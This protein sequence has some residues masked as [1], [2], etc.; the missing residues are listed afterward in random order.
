ME[1]SKAVRAELA[2]AMPKRRC[3]QQAELVA[4]VRFLG[5]RE[6]DVVDVATSHPAVARKVFLLGKGVPGVHVEGAEPTGA[7][8]QRYNVRLRLEEAAVDAVPRRDCCARAYLR[9]AWLSRGSV[10]DP[11]AGYHL[12]IVLPS[13]AEAA[14]VQG[15]LQRY[16]IG[17]G[18]SLRKG[19]HVVYVKDADG[20]AEFLRLTGAHGALLT[21]ED[22]RV[23]KHMRNRVNRLVNA[24]TANMEKVVG[25][26]LRQA[27]DIRLIE[28]LQGLEK[29]PS[30][31]KEVARLRLAHPDLS[32]AE[33]GRRLTPPLSK[34]AVNHRMRRLAQIADDLRRTLTAPS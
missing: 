17:A 25:A 18:V 33:L 24:E 14:Q 29:L 22:Y 10:S 13:A 28:R 12:E 11:E 7:G 32:L 20:I 6:T 26:A 34:S 23:L 1:F 31:L 21:W 2:R 5:R 3:C 9:G 16:D 30:S 15:L 27:E 19:D 4:L 8:R